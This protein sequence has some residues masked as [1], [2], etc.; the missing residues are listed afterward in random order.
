ML[1]LCHELGRSASPNFKLTHYP[2]AP[3]QSRNL[4]RRNNYLQMQFW[5]NPLNQRSGFVPS[6]NSA[7]LVHT[8]VI[9]LR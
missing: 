1:A 6:W 9:I 2:P 4:L 8:P 5:K 7:K 3:L